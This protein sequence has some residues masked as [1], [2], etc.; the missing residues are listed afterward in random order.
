M[1]L[2]VSKDLIQ[3]WN[4]LIPVDDL[5]EMS[6]NR[7]VLVHPYYTRKLYFPPMDEI[8]FHIQKNSHHKLRY[9][10]IDDAMNDYIEYR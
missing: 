5:H 1:A 6:N 10:R 4:H 7:L 9:H 3:S 2:D 8:E